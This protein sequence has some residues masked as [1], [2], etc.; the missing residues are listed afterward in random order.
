MVLSIF[1]LLT[2]AVIPFVVTIVLNIYALVHTFIFNYKNKRIRR[3]GNNTTAII[4]IS[5]ICWLFVLSWIPYIVHVYMTIIRKE[6]SHW[7]YLCQ[8]NVNI[9]S[10]SLNP[11]IYTLTNRR[12]RRFMKQRVVMS[13]RRLRVKYVSRCKVDIARDTTNND[14]AVIQDRSRDEVSRS[15]YFN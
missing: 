11:L 2:L 4:T 7:F 12:L 15:T 6:I 14:S 9:L 1:S 3:A 5:S 10:L 8:Y 13:K